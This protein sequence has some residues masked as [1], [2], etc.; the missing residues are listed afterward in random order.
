MNVKIIAIL[1]KLFFLY[2]LYGISWF[3]APNFKKFEGDIAVDLSVGASVRP[4][5]TSLR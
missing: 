4:S 3:Y 1:L 2:W 5:V